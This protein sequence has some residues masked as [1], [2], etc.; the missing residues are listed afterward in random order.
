MSAEEQA[1]YSPGNALFVCNKCDTIPQKEAKDVKTHITEKL[2][3]S[4]PD[5]DTDTQIVYLSTAKAIHAQTLGV[6]NEALDNLLT[7]IKRLVLNSMQA[8]LEVSWR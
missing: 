7:N 3:K 6:V 1:G 5:I 4:W 2:K 8:R